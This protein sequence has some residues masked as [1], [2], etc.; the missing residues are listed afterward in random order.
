M[1]SRDYDSLDFEE[2]W[3]SECCVFSICPRG[4]A[5]EN[6]LVKKGN[7]DKIYV[8]MSLLSIKHIGYRKIVM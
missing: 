4:I 7:E 3:G 1:P 8:Y 6:N 5:D 2:K